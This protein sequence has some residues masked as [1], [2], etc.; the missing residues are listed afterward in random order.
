MSLRWRI[1]WLFILFVC[2]LMFSRSYVNYTATR[3]GLYNQA[4]HETEARALGIKQLLTPHSLD[5]PLPPDLLYR[6]SLDDETTLVQV[7][8]RQGEIVS[9]SPE[10]KQQ[11][12]PLIKVGDTRIMTF[13]VPHLGT[14]HA[15]LHNQAIRRNG[16]PVATIQ[17]ARP[18]KEEDALLQDLLWIKLFTFLISLIAA[19]ALGHILAKRAL[20]PVVRIIKQVK[21]MSP[22]D[23]SQR[24]QTGNL[25]RDEIGEL[26]ETFNQLLAR[27]DSAFQAQQAF[28]SDASH[29]L[30]SPLTTIRGYAQQ[31]IKRGDKHP[32]LLKVGLQVI[33]RESERLNRLV[34]DLLSLARSEEAAETRVP[35]D[36]VAIAR[37]VAETMGP[38]HPN[39]RL[40]GLLNQLWVEGDPDALKRVLLNL[41]DNA[42]RAAGSGGDV[43]VSWGQVSS[44]AEI[45][46]RDN[47]H[48][49][50]PEHLPRLFDRFYRVDEARDRDHGGTGL[51]LSIVHQIVQRHH[52]EIVVVSEPGQGACFLVRL[53]KATAAR[54]ASVRGRS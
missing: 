17:I 21:S 5:R 36:L 6:Y 25:T 1:T 15:V 3:D 12:L 27:I 41:I 26:A 34:D 23:L 18:L 44:H 37:E 50:A 47:G 40:E 35:V 16:Q 31:L 28:V 13:D 22:Q 51:G 29:E 32:E 19:A 24:V 43:V 30:R 48:G 42:L 11:A 9:R 38:L 54:A 46:V 45:Q 4:V 10:L 14:L 8:N 39:L 2:T 49:I 7:M 33:A 53:P 20:A 52:G